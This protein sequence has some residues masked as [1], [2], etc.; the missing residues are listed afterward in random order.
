[1]GIGGAIG[2]IVDKMPNGVGAGRQIVGTDGDNRIEGTGGSDDILADP[3]PADDSGGDD[4]VWGFAGDD[5]IYGFGGDNFLDGGPGDDE[6]QGGRNSDLLRGG[7]GNDEVRGGEGDDALYGDAGDD[8]VIGSSGNDLV[9]GG[10][11]IDQLEGREGV[12]RFAWESAAE[13][14]DTVLDFALAVDRLV[15]GDFLSGFS[16]D[17]SDLE[18]YVRFV[19]A[20]GGS[21]SVL[22]VD[23]DG[24]GSAGWRE[25]TLVAGQPSLSALPLYQVGDLELKGHAPA[26]PFGPLAYI[27]SYDDLIGAFGADPAAGKLHYLATGHDEGRTVAFDGLQYIA[28]YGDLIGTIGADRSAGADHFIRSGFGE[29]RQRD[30]FDEVQYVANYA[31][32]QAAFGDD[33]EAATR[34]Y[35]TEGH[36]E[37][38]TDQP[39]TAAT[40]FIL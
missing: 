1:M 32:L 10:V 36:R 39:L 33:Y 2:D 13:D 7:P 35:I 34:H 25:L 3:I 8:R 29:N 5:R 14:R 9:Y 31:D 17:E 16:G 24:A 11:G 21:A 30:T 15:I 23:R 38:R 4:Q 20:D 40:D 12:D 26:A 6:I 28:S 22:Q 37:G 27:A 18:R 19:A